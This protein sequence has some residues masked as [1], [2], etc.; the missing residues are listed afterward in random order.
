MDQVYTMHRRARDRTRIM[1]DQPLE[2]RYWATTLGCTQPELLT[3]ISAVGSG[4]DRV[5]QYLNRA[6]LRVI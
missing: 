1:E 3:A 5:R 2:L 4:S 6:W